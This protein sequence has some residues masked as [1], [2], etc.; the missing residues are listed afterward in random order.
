MSP[1]Q[2]IR[3]LR[4]S[5][6][7]SVNEFAARTGN[8]DDQLP[9]AATWNNDLRRGVERSAGGGGNVTPNW[10]KKRQ[11]SAAARKG[12]PKG[13]PTERKT[14]TPLTIEKPSP[15]SGGDLLEDGHWHI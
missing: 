14:G 7:Q 9:F 15:E 8:G 5:P 2:G 13:S 12:C 1:P 11:A 4:G 10:A 6:S 3:H